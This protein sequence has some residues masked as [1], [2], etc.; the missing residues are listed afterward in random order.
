[1]RKIGFSNTCT[2]CTV[3]PTWHTVVQLNV[4]PHAQSVPIGCTVVCPWQHMIFQVFRFRRFAHKI[5]IVDPFSIPFFHTCSNHLNLS[6]STVKSC[7]PISNQLNQ[8]S[9]KSLILQKR[10]KRLLHQKI[11]FLPNNPTP[12]TYSSKINYNYANSTQQ[13]HHQFTWIHQNQTPPFLPIF[14]KTIKHHNLITTAHL[15]TLK[16]W[17]I[18]TNILN[19]IHI[20]TS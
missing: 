16:A 11:H 14:T 5:S 9:P 12:K 13:Q 18:I 7:F 1:M 17:I 15:A 2:G 19:S 10:L 3:V 20:V 8:T 4:E 6:D